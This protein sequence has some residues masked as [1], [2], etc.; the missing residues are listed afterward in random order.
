M[1][2]NERGNRAMALLITA[3]MA[4]MFTAPDTLP[5]QRRPVPTPPPPTRDSLGVRAPGDEAAS[6]ILGEYYGE[7]QK[8]MQ[9]LMLSQFAVLARPETAKHLARFTKNY[10]DQL[11][12]LGFSREEALRI[13][14]ARDIPLPGLPR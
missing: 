12:A 8:S 5:A 10:F 13:V 3:G 4:S 7:V 6:A 9:A 1:R 2:K 14:T 11:V